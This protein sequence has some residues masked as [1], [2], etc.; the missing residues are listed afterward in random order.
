MGLG[1]GTGYSTAGYYKPSGISNRTTTNE[2]T[3]IQPQAETKDRSKDGK[4]SFWQAAKNFGK[5]LISPITSMFS[6]P[7]NFLIGAGTI[8]AGGALIVATGGAAAP[9]LLALGI[10]MSGYQIGQGV[11]KFATAKNGDE[12]EEAFHDMGAGT[13]GL[14]LSA[15]GAKASLKGAGVA[16][17]QVDN[18]SMIQATTQN[19]RQTPSS[20]GKSVNMFRTGDA[21]ANLSN[22]VR[23]LSS[24]RVRAKAEAATAAEAKLFSDL[25]LLDESV[26]V[27]D[28]GSNQIK[29]I[30]RLPD[31]SVQEA[32]FS[33]G[34]GKSLGEHGK[35][36]PQARQQLE[37]SWQQSQEFLKK[38]GVASERTEAIA[39]EGLRAAGKPGEEI[40]QQLGI[41][42]IDGQQEGSYVYQSVMRGQNPTDGNAMV[43]EV[44]GG[45]TEWAFANGESNRLLSLGTARNAPKDPFN[46]QEISAARQTIRSDVRASVNDEVLAA[47]KGNEVY[48]SS[49]SELRDIHLR[50]T[51]K[52]L[53]KE[54]L[55]LDEINYYLSPE[56]LAK[57]QQ[58]G[59]DNTWVRMLPTKFA[60][61]AE[62]MEAL[63][64]RTVRFGSPGGMK[65]GVM[66]DVILRHHPEAAR[67]AKL[68]TAVQELEPI[69]ETLAQRNKE[70]FADSIAQVDEI[71]GEH[72]RVIG[73]PKSDS[74]VT[75]KL[76][77][78]VIDKGREYP[79][80]EA[81]TPDVG[82][83]IGTR[84]I[85][86][87]G[88]AAEAD[89]VAQSLATAIREGKIEI[90][91][92]NNYRGADGLPYFTDEHVQAFMK[93][94]DIAKSKSLS[95]VGSEEMTIV[96]TGEKATK[97][98]GY[99]TTQM[100]VRHRNG[101]LGELQIRGP[102]IDRFAEIEHIIYDMR[103]GKTLAGDF[104]SALR[105]Q[106]DGVR[107]TL[108]GLS[109]EQFD[110]YLAYVSDDYKRYRM[111]ENGV[112]N[113]PEPML[114]Q[115]LQ[116]FPH[117]ELGNIDRLH[118]MVLGVKNL[119]KVSPLLPFQVG[120]GSNIDS[121][122]LNRQYIYA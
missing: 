105:S 114:P 67:D 4:F 10:G 98:S 66:Q 21:Q 89:Q 57:L 71:F 74:S 64:L 122:F 36:T 30:I 8:L 49:K 29:T 44:G 108:K 121:P 22:T 93:S 9:A 102:Q 19:I 53:L 15:V 119:K 2:N 41:R 35:I 109:K 31:G 54:P 106:L 120:N 118:S 81:A 96:N 17:D 47:A 103:Q 75:D 26:A 25:P 24:F 116:E 69:G 23:S 18:M 77:R 83:A 12:R 84:L 51:G 85:M 68:R 52:D 99:T 43:M 3:V 58:L 65:A 6:S 113:V 70:Q 104:P 91:E 40:A 61:L 73:R 1:I 20:I 50:L 92:I 13:G 37:A 11:Y 5:G 39:T 117:L 97:A 94:A 46:P 112:T 63:G 16:A 62:S 27:V 115:S 59:G 80:A 78:K 95:T 33:I 110:T 111:I 56:G 45:S 107:G 72:G 48:I 34:L 7:K 42:I 100:N 28:V 90:T 101:A 82:D 88:S 87:N 79:T 14:A 38:H 76:A 55:K 32:N 86:R 60:I